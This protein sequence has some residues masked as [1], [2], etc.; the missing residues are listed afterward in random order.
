M[1][2]LSIP[3]IYMVDRKV[4]TMENKYD[5][6]TMLEPVPFWQL[7][8]LFP[9]QFEFRTEHSLGECVQLITTLNMPNN[10]WNNRFNSHMEVVIAERQLD[11]YDFAIM[12][13]GKNKLP[14]SEAEGILLK[15]DTG[16][17]VWGRVIFAPDL[18][19]RLVIY[20]LLMPCFF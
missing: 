7:P 11:V 10:N 1:F 13:I 4:Q 6:R 3:T 15:D 8:L 16:T 9:K 20:V 12:G 14:Y 19:A 5:A 2:Q 17:I 18:F